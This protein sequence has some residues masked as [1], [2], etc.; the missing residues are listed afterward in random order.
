MWTESGSEQ[1]YSC[2]SAFGSGFC[3][4]DSSSPSSYAVTTSTVSA[5]PS[6]YSAPTM[7]SDLATAFGTASSIPIPAIPTSYYPGAAQ[8]SKL[9]GSATVQGAA[10]IVGTASQATSTVEAVG[11]STL[12]ATSSSA[13]A[14]SV[15]SATASTLVTSTV[16]NSASSTSVAATA[17][18]SASSKK[19]RKGRHGQSQG[20]PATC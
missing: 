14:S 10:K 15:A 18:T 16:A 3:L 11:A 5:A 4:K 19:G 8:I 7:A 17:S 13:S 9:S 6:G 20:G 2:E 12:S 1:W